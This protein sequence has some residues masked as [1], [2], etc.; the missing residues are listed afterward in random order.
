M[1]LYDEKTGDLITWLKTQSAITAV[2]GTG[3]N[4]QIFPR[5]EPQ[6]ITGQALVFDRVTGQQYRH[7]AGESKIRRD[8]VHFYSYGD[9]ASEADAL[10][11]LLHD[12]LC[13]SGVETRNATWGT[14]QI[15]LVRQLD[16]PT[17]GEDVPVKA[18][19]RYRYWTMSAYEIFVRQT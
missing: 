9:K 8:V 1:G 18:D 14:S 16:G 6:D 15:N 17:S 10:D 19:A 13:P 11:E 3:T 5:R 7:L 4:A 12:A 2:V